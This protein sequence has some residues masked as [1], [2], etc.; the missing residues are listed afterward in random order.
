MDKLGIGT[1]ATIAQHIE[2]IQD[3]AMPIQ[4]SAVQVVPA[5]LA[6]TAGVIGA[7]LLINS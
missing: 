3:R 6:N 7:S 4:A 5:Q 2:T 1:D